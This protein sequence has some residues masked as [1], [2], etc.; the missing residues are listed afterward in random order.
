MGCVS[1]LVHNLATDGRSAL[2]LPEAT[3]S[4]GQLGPRGSAADAIRRALSQDAPPR[5][6]GGRRRGAGAAGAVSK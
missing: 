6:V 1:A 3:Y 5:G 2:L 4:L